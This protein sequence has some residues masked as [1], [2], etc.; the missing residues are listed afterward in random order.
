MMGLSELSKDI[1]QL[2]GIHLNDPFD[3]FSLRMCC[4]HF[5]EC[6][7]G[8]ESEPIWRKLVTQDEAKEED[9]DISWKVKYVSRKVC[10]LN[11]DIVVPAKKDEG[12]F[13]KIG[14]LLKSKKREVIN[15]AV[16]GLRGAG[17]TSILK[18][19]EEEGHFRR[20][21]GCNTLYLNNG[22]D[23]K[24]D[25]ALIEVESVLGLLESPRRNQIDACIFVLDSC[26]VSPDVKIALWTLR[27]FLEKWKDRK[28]PLLVFANK[29]DKPSKLSVPDIYERLGI[30][31]TTLKWFIRESRVFHYG[32]NKE[33]T[34][35]Q[36]VSEGLD[37]ILSVTQ[38]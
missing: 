22:G 15:V 25:V 35:C 31:S 27:V 10:F 34:D 16:T 9:E 11:F 12:F 2:I 30:G 4:K 7:L 37:W 19:F 8:K 24:K 6:L 14:S 18:S 36:G 20:I 21:A 17:K 29:Q 32:L 38:K 3:I 28:I 13:G 23:K 26:D 1:I 5:C 33:F